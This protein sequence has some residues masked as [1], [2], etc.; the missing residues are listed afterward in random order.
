MDDT[1]EQCPEQ[2]VTEQASED[3]HG[4]DIKWAAKVCAGAGLGLDQEDEC[5]EEGRSDKVEDKARPVGEAQDTG[6]QA[7]DGRVG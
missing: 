1:V 5:G 6:G 3:T 2:D 7:E 4:E